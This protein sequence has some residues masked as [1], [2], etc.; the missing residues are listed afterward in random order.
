MAAD[1]AGLAGQLLASRYRIGDRI[2]EGGMGVV[3]EA[4]DEQLRRPVAVKFLPPALRSDDDRLG[5]FRN[6]AR[7]LSAL[8]HP[9]IITIFEIG[10]TQ[11]TPFIAM[12][13]VDGETLRARL[14]AGRLPLRDA[15]EIALQVARA[16][17]AAHE[18]GIVH[19][20]IKPE[21]VMI[22]RDGYVKVLDFGLA[23]L[24]ARENETP[25]ML[26]GG[27]L[28]TVLAG[29]AGTPS[30]MSPEQIDG[31]AL[32]P[33]SDLFSL[34]VLLCEMV[35]GTNPFAGEGLVETISAIQRTPLPAAPIT[36]ELPRDARSIILK[37][38]QRDPAD[39]YQTSAEL[40]ADLRNLLGTLD[41]PA[42]AQ[43]VSRPR[44]RAL[45]VAAVLALAVAL[46]AGAVVYRSSERRQ[47]VREQ[48]TPEI[49]KL[50]AA[51]RGVAAFQLIKEAEKY[52][53]GD[54]DLAR[55]AASATRVATVRSTPPG[56]VVEVED[57]LSPSGTWHRLG[58]TPL[59]KVRMPAGYL[60]W[61]VSKPG[62]GELIAAPVAGD[63][64]DFD[65]ETA[66][67]APAG[68][69]PV[70]G[71]PWTDS[72][73]FLGWVGPY[74]LPPFFID[75][76]EVTNRQYQVFVDKGGYATPGYWTQPFVRD[77]HEL[78]WSQAMDLFRD[79]TGRPGPSTWEGGHY[80]EGKADYP[81]SGVSWFEALAY[82]EF[83]GK[84]LPVIAQG[85]KVMPPVLDRFALAESN[86]SGN[87][88]PVGQFAGLGPFGTFDL[89]GNVREWYWNAANDDLR[90]TLGR[91]ANSYGP[92]ALTPFD[93]SALNG[94]R[95]VR[96]GGR[97]PDEAKAPRVM[98]RRDFSTAMPVNDAAFKIYRDMYAYDAAPLNATSQAMADPSVDWTREKVTFNAAY[99]GE[100]MSAYLF[101]PKNTKPPYQAVVFFPSA[102]VNFLS[103]SAELGDMSF[104][105]YVIKSG[106]AVIYPVYQKL[107]ERRAATV[108]LPGPTLQRQTL[109][110]WRKDV[111]RSID[112]LETRDDIDKNRIAY[113]GVSQGSA[114]GVIL[115]A[116]EG[117]F[118]AVVL[119]DGGMFQQTAGLAGLDQVDFAPRLTKPVLMVN[120][121]YDATFPY[122]SAQ[123]PL[124]RM[125]G[126]A[127]ADKRHVVFDTPHDVRLR[128]TE[129]VK[130]VLEWYDKYL[131]R[132]Q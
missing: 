36:D 69:M 132:V 58:T 46:G 92:E 112:Y 125:V 13:F 57:Y 105:D 16:L 41:M 118:K 98:L 87:P 114:Y 126:T 71:G 63:T 119:L 20:D 31:R 18:K 7:T 97:I 123:L 56:A 86:L 77:G 75:R 27:S 60:R 109:V 9:H 1:D 26:T 100:R 62:I 131:G 14:R 53:P 45:A 68:M 113:L 130:E 33:R 102:R 55:A 11:T 122:E 81:V 94:F 80:P 51:D 61:R 35:T 91:Q 78:S 85:F 124:F 103:S 43:A 24:R 22:R 82:A 8:N 93:R 107:Y 89:I 6:E 54:P 90:Y 95:C 19:R 29:V 39:R 42:R 96:N 2:G 30:Y 52:S 3:Y 104:V 88:A 38:L 23:V 10:Q 111:G 115:A 40:Q 15:V 28:E 5:R 72:L 76:F 84:S 120:G 127:A 47:W 65:L 74:V 21:N 59:D 67:K 64:M 17:G 79:A 110:D 50:A 4:F 25:S 32:D 117:R 37:L 128:R 44:K 108:T 101:L 49:V 116:L 73:A 129:L 121:R 66:A 34:G 99:D 12:E 83:V 48:A 106:R 70:S